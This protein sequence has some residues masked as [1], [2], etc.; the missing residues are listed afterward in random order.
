MAQKA[1]PYGLHAKAVRRYLSKY[2]PLNMISNVSIAYSGL[3][4][5]V[6]TMTMYV[7]QTELDEVLRCM[8]AEELTKEA[9]E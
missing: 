4:P 9:G 3:D 6:I 2:V 8:V 5:C 1:R 7:D